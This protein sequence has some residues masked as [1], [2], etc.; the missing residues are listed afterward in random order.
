MG[1]A[2]SPIPVYY[3]FRLDTARVRYVSRIRP[4]SIFNSVPRYAMSAHRNVFPN[5]RTLN[6]SGTPHRQLTLPKIYRATR[7]P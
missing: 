5:F 4:N 3:E 6:R 2:T 1:I 7:E